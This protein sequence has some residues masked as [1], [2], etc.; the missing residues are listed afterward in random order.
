MGEGWGEGLEVQLYPLP[1]GEGEKSRE[2]FTRAKSV[3]GGDC[4]VDGE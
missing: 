2:L 3:K 1:K 4:Y